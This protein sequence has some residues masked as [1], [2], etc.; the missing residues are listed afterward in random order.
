VYQSWRAFLNHLSNF[1][2]FGNVYVEFYAT[3]NSPRCGIFKNASA[4]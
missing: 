2:A 1:I 4:A 3:V